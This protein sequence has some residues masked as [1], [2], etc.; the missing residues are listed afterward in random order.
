MKFKYKYAAAWVLTTSVRKN[1]N[2]FYK[3]VLFAFLETPPHN[4]AML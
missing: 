2:V 4:I 3:V 1:N